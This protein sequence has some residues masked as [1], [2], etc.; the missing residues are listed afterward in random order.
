MGVEKG[1]KITISPATLG[2]AEGKKVTIRWSQNLQART[3]EYWVTK[4]T[5]KTSGQRQT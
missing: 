5:N 1:N 3:E 4:F 2:G